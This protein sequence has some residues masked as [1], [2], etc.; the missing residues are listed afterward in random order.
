M[1]DAIVSPVRGRR[2]P[3]LGP[4]AVVAATP[5]DLKAVCRRVLPADGRRQHALYISRLYAP[6]ASHAGVAVAGPVVGAPYA[7]MIAETL[8]AW[9]VRKIIFFGWCGAISPQLAIGDVVVPTAAV[10]DEGTSRH[11]RPVGAMYTENRHFPD[12][13]EISTPSMPM[14]D[15]LMQAAARRNCPVATGRIW[16]TDGIYRETP[17]KVLHYRKMGCLA[18][19]M[20]LSALFSVAA[21]RRVDLAGVLVVSDNLSA[22]SWQPGFRQP[23]FKRGRKAAAEIAAELAQCLAEGREEACP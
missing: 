19:E 6:V 14:A 1:H 15:A 5:G 20:E 22:L 23:E 11:Y 17:D 21:F 3:R 7:A 13:P 16:S 12:V 10:I 8:V 9:G 4:V 2:S 18:V